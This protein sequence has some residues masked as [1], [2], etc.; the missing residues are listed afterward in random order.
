MNWLYM[1]E[2]LWD[3]YDV[4]IPRDKK[5]VFLI[6]ENGTNK[7]NTLELLQRHFEKQGD[8]VVFFT[9][10]RL[11][12]VTE[13]DVY[14]AIDKWEET[15]PDRLR[16]T[17]G[18]PLSPWF[19]QF[20]EEFSV[21]ATIGPEYG[22]MRGDRQLVSFFT[23]IMLAPA[24]P[25]VL[26]DE[27]EQGLSITHQEKL[28]KAL[29]ELPVNRLIIATHSPYIIHPF[30]EG[31]WSMEDICVEGGDEDDDDDTTR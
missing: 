22:Y 1:D 5:A 8:P 7:T 30:D 16:H 4:R 3:H 31:V 23:R 28:I 21:S 15:H 11:F 14:Q 13:E 18:K 10:H 26:I 2:K 27:P 24:P 19:D 25:V 29:L 17:L 12:G 9:D 6:G 20:V